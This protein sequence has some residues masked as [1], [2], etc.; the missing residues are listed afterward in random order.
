M[1]TYYPRRLL[2]TLPVLLGVSLLVFSM[3]HLVP[4]D[5]VKMMLSEFATQPEQLE[6]LRSQLHLDD[7]LPQQFGRFVWNA[8]AG[9]SGLLDPQQA[10]GDGRNRGK[11]AVYTRT[12]PRRA[13]CSL[14]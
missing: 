4:G 12:C 3:L 14:R 9:R 2:H 6:K 13:A 7:P 1:T 10:T 8:A 5:P 11:P